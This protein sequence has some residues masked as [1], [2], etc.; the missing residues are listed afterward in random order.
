VGNRTPTR[1]LERW[2]IIMFRFLCDDPECGCREAIEEALRGMV[3]A[4]RSQCSPSRRPY[5]TMG[6][7]EI[8]FAIPEDKGGGSLK[9]VTH[10]CEPEQ[11]PVEDT[12]VFSVPVHRQEI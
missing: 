2:R 5:L 3:T 10:E 6:K 12:D 7:V 11:I 1:I 8:E 9:F 4:V